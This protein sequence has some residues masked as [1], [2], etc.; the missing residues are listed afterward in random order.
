[1]NNHN[2]PSRT[3]PEK[4]D[5]TSNAGSGIVPESAYCP[6]TVPFKVR[7]RNVTLSVI[8]LI[9]GTFG[10]ITNNFVLPAKRGVLTLYG[11]PAWVMYGSLLCLVTNLTAV[12]IDHYD[13][14]NNEKRYA[15]LKKMSERVGWTLFVLALI[16]N[17]IKHSQDFV[18]ENKVV[19]KSTNEKLGLTAFAYNRY[20]ALHNP[21]NDI[22]PS[23]QV[24]VI[25][26]ASTL[27]VDYRIVTHMN[28]TEIVRMYW[29][30]EKLLIEYHPRQDKKRG[31]T[32]PTVGIDTPVPV[33]L[34]NVNPSPG[35]QHD[36]AVLGP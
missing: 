33:K 14:R 11:Y 9:Y 3:T 27:P 7:L 34:I 16:L 1:M 21:F 23:L 10:V 26:V 15:K 20:C 32:L 4:S 5:C 22:E 24:T 17:G 36:K 8:L 2:M 35:S 6:N 30:E 19:I 28:R 31:T 25:P 13:T 18:C 29:A 12:V